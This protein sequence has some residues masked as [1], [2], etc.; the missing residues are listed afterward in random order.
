M[1][2]WVGVSG[3]RVDWN[4]VLVCVRVD[5]NGVLVCVNKRSVEDEVIISHISPGNQS[6]ILPTAACSPCMATTKSTGGT[7]GS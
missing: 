5:R 6:I 7:G 2:G 3:V 1:Y 4:R